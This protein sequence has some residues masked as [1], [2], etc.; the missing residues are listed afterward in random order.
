MRAL[1]LG[2]TFCCLMFCAGCGLGGD[3][4]PRVIGNFSNSSLS[5]RYTYQIKGFDR[6]AGNG[7][8]I[9]V[10]AGSFTADGAGHLTNGTDE[11]STGAGAATLGTSSGTYSISRDGTGTL[12]LNTTQAGTLSFAVTLASSS[13]FYLIEADTFANAFGTAEKQDTTAFT[14]A[15]SGTFVFRLHEVSG[16]QPVGSVGQLTVAGGSF[17]GQEDLLALGNALS[18]HTISNGTFTAP[19]T[20][21]GRGTGA[22]TD[23]TGFI[24]NFVYYVVNSGTLR[25][26]ST[27]QDT[28][29]L[30]R[31][32]VQTAGPF[33]AGSFS[34][35]YAFGSAG[36]T[37]TV[38]LVNFDAANTVGRYTAGGDGL[39]SSGTYDSVRDGTPSINISAS[40]SYTITPNGRVDARVNNTVH[41]IFWLV[42]PSRAF[43]V[44][45]VD[46]L[47]KV[48]DGTADRQQPS[49]FANSTMTGQF[50]L[51]M[52]G[53]D[54][55]TDTDRVGTL[56][57]GGSAANLALNE[58][59]N[60]GGNINTAFLN[61]NF[62]VASNGRTTAT[63]PFNAGS[64]NLVFYLVSG[65]DA[66][67]LLSDPGI[68]INGV[69]SKQP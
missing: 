3:G 50:A 55:G 7:G 69:I 68:V 1:S 45:D 43:F 34:G 62:S 41:D 38:A 37:G 60:I 36:D 28:L 48:E 42:S 18:S 57:W 21:T 33:N 54:N 67:F 64:S 56:Q 16:G 47:T 19:N 66:Y 58:F 46:D 53:L 23:N 15:P 29:G 6:G 5:G 39:I 25:L 31:A 59:V 9:F 13:K 44:R 40:G 14:S 4:N 10:E 65:A 12:V 30:G 24:T 63:L 49:S 51:A 11:F 20:T 26:F 52:G 35:G 61:G 22:F 8:S 2:L 32:E 17:T 27:T